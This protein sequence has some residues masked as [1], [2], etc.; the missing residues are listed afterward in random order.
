MSARRRGIGRRVPP[1]LALVAVLA[2]G[3]ASLGAL[4]GGSID[5][6]A[7]RVTPD[8]EEVARLH[9]E[10]AR[11]R[12]RLRAERARSS[13][14]ASEL[15][16]RGRTQLERE[17][18]WRDLYTHLERLRTASDP[19]QRL[20]EALGLEVEAQRRVEA[21]RTERARRELDAARR[22]ADRVRRALN[23]RL[24]VEGVDGFDL[25]DIGVLA[26]DRKGLSAVAGALA[27]GADAP[28]D[29]AT[30]TAE[31]ASGSGV[32]DDGAPPTNESSDKSSDESTA[33]TAAAG[34]DREAAAEP[35]PAFGTGP[36]VLRLFDHRGFLAGSIVA[37][38]LHLEASRSGHSVTLVLTDGHQQVDGARLPFA[39]GVYRIPLR[40]T[41][42][43]PFIDSCGELFDPERVERIVDDGRWSRP[44]LVLTLNRLLARSDRRSGYRLSWLGGVVG[45]ELREVEVSVYDEAGDLSERMIA[46]GLV[47]ELHSDH[48]RLA[49]RDGLSLG[50]AGSRTPFREGRRTI[51]LVGSDPGAYAS[52]HL[53]V[54][55]LREQAAS[56]AESE[57]P[58]SAGDGR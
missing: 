43:V 28:G 54:V 18:A 22:R 15:A 19:A 34:A 16:R 50:G 40:S 14:L 12:H 41:D 5:G 2:S 32:A 17:L 39:G 31:E 51:V 7:T 21:E 10:N 9:A 35:D 26:S 47:I 53:P 38:R 52:A 56:G 44:A 1:T 3:L 13:A 57:A 42:P 4:T 23:A 29:G 46:D 33:V 27:G 58:V 48:V 36:V 49:L 11:L 37:Q 24:R 25:F 8:A 20:V 6:G 30:S 55:D 45:D